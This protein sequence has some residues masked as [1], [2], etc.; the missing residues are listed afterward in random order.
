MR[1][2]NYSAQ[3][4]TISIYN[5]VST[6]KVFFPFMFSSIRPTDATAAAAADRYV[7]CACVVC[8]RNNV[9][10]QQRTHGGRVLLDGLVTSMRVDKFVGLF[11]LDLMRN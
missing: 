2:V 5:N 11:W 4:T 7:V 10:Q 6:H 3:S 1:V 9:I 8:L